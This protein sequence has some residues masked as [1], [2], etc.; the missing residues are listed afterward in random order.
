MPRNRNCRRVSAPP[1]MIGFEPF[2]I[3]K[4][5]TLQDPVTLNYDEFE[6]IKLLDYQNMTQEEAATQMGVSRPTITRIYERARIAVATALAEGR[7]LIIE[8]G[9]VDFGTR[10]ERCKNC[11]EILD[12]QS[13]AQHKRCGCRGNAKGNFERGWNENM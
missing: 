7:T 6:S 10:W 5:R 9:N 2:G 3:S 1:S 12:E 13:S 11:F 8:G 4:R